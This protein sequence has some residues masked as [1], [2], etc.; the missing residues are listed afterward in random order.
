MHAVLAATSGEGGAGPSGGTPAFWHV[1][2][3]GKGVGHRVCLVVEVDD[4][5]DRPLG[6]IPIFAT[7]ITNL[8]IGTAP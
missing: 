1:A 4:V 7:P 8:F 5:P 2:L 3:C 6:L